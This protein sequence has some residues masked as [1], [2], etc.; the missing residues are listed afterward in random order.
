M[1]VVVFFSSSRDCIG[2]QYKSI[3]DE[4]AALQSV[5][6]RGKILVNGSVKRLVTSGE[7]TV[8][9]GREVH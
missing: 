9:R 3:Q 1:L 4:V 2:A 5:I 6:E 7:L 8:V